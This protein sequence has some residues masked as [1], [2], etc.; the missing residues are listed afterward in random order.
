MTPQNTPFDFVCAQARRAAMISSVADTL[1]WD[2][3]TRMPPAAGEYRAIQ[4]S[5]L[6]AMAHEIRT[7]ARYGD[8]LG[9]LSIANANNEDE[10]ATIRDLKRDW[11]R[12]SRLPVD[13]VRRISEATVKGQQVWTQARKSDDFASFAPQLGQIVSLIRESGQRLADGTDRS[14]YEALMDEYEPDADVASLNQV[15]ADLRVE[16]SQLIQTI[17]QAPRQP[18]VSIL[19]REYCLDTQRDFS[20]RVAKAVGFDFDRGRLDETTHPFCT[21]L[22]PSDIRILTR[23][24]IDWLPAGLFATLH[25]AGHGMYEQGLRTDWFGLPP[26]KYVSLGI[27]ESQSRLWENQVGRSLAFWKWLYADAQETFSPVL[28]DV[29]LTDFHFAINQ[30]QPS[31]IRVEADEATYNLHILIRF[32]LEQKLIEEDFPI[33]DLPAEWNRQYQECLGVQSD[34]DSEG[35]LQDVH[36]SAGLFGYF[37]TYTLGNLAATQLFHAAQSQIGDVNEMFA[38]GQFAPLLGWL[39]ENVHQHGARHSSSELIKD[40]SGEELN[41]SYLINDLKGKLLPLYGM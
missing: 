14:V 33:D 2:E 40:A 5:S 4:V 24:Q 36:W 41:A 8:E 30:V 35:V 23:Y 26:G 20:Q 15:F 34:T 27:H 22:G 3:Q 7:E 17:R 1:E 29:E 18:D 32:D 6:R 37:P 21:T 39:R 38:A 13:L 12:D 10:A 31:L 9:G 11:N 16:L 25:E 19:Q 28:N